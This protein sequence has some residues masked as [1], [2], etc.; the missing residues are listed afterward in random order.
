MGAK[1]RNFYIFEADEKTIE[2]TAQPLL[3]VWGWFFLLCTL[4]FFILQLAQVWSL[5]GFKQMEANMGHH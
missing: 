3:P 2:E 1:V 5:P 4:A